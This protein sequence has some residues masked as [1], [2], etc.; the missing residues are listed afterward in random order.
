MSIKYSKIFGWI[1]ILAGLALIAWTLLF[2]YAIFTGEK[3]APL[4]FSLPEQAA[5]DREENIFPEQVD[6]EEMI[7]QQISQVL[8][9]EN[10]FHLFNLLAWSLLAFIFIFAAGQIAGLGVKMIKNDRSS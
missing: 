9:L 1:L 10:I 2:S 5:P 8:P 4:I 6:V 3:E 7:S